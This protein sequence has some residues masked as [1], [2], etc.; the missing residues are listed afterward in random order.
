MKAVFGLFYIILMF[1][2]CCSTN[3][4]QSLNNL[5]QGIKGYVSEI[6]GNQMPGPDRKQEPAKG[7]QTE[8][9]IYEVTTMDQVEAVNH[10]PF[11]R[12]IRS[13]FIKS[14][15]S[16][17]DG[18]FATDLEP[19]TYSLFTKV[20]GLYYANS[21]NGKNQIQSVEV[22]QDSI[23]EVNIIISAKATF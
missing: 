9:Y 19:G 18:F 1:S 21:F 3:N 6:K 8:V 15:I 23:S 12:S 20:D 22:L 13:K 10:E 17:K 16:D 4:A 11:Y 14:I 7:F 2:A 5:K